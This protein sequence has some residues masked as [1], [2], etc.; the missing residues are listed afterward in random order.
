MLAASLFE[1]AAGAMV[2]LGTPHTRTANV[3]V[4]KFDAD[5]PQVAS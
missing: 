4:N 2:A 5:Q 1:L 3:L